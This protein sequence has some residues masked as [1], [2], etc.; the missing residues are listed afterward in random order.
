LILAIQKFLEKDLLK[1][2]SMEAMLNVSLRGVFLIAGFCGGLRGE[3]L[4]LMNLDATAK[5]LLVAQPRLPEI[6]NVCL[7]LR[8][9]VKG[10]ALEEACHL[11]PIADVTASGLTPHLWV[12]GAV[13]A[14]ANLG[15]SNSWMFRNKKGE[16][17][18]MGFYETY[19]FELIQRVQDAGTVAEIFL[20]RDDDITVS[21]GIARSGRRGYAT[22]T[23]NIGIPDADI[24]QLARWRAIDAAAGRAASLPGGGQ[25]GIL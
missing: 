13:E 17:E 7:A 5:Y 8:V 24:K 18:R 9:R 12:C 21:H 2:Q 23:T 25:G 4:P 16:A 20:P 10:E 22:H 3:E 1:C 6:A 15:I 19:M 11:V 14:Y